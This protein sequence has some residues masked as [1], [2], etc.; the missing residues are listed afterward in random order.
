[1]NFFFVMSVEIGT[2][3][4]KAVSHTCK[5]VQLRQKKM[6]YKIPNGQKNLADLRISGYEKMFPLKSLQMTRCISCWRV[7]G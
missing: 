3:I 6:K 1:M 5:A 7:R 2:W 4:Q